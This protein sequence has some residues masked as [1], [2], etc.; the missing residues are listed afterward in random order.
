MNINGLTTP[1]FYHPN[2]GSFLD[3]DLPIL[4]VIIACRSTEYSQKALEMQQSLYQGQAHY[5]TAQ[6]FNNIGVAYIELGDKVKGAEYL[7]KAYIIYLDHSLG[8]KQIQ[9]L[10]EWLVSNTPE[11]IT[12]SSTRMFITER[13]EFSENILQI[14][15]KLQ[16]PV[17]NELQKLCA[18]KDGWNDGII[19]SGANSYLEDNYLR[20]QLGDLA[21]E[22][23]LKIAK[24]LCFEAIALGIMSKLE[25][26]RDLGC[27]IGFAYQYPQLLKIIAHEHPEY[28]V[29][30]SILQAV[31]NVIGDDEL[32]NSL[33]GETL[34][35]NHNLD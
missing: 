12:E 20:K 10:H 13:G 34:H 17:L 19:L 6:S 16:S 18:E 4:W 14:Q 21:T 26:D 22:E 27:V 2:G 8:D 1:T 31:S 3:A 32:V 29:D 33:I 15:L 11:F 7:K 9:I 5:A 30:G 35:V 23:N 24:E 25:A 28:F